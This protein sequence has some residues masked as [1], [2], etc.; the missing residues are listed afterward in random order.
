M[1]FR[2]TRKADKAKEFDEEFSSMNDDFTGV[3]VASNTECTG[4]MSTPP[5]NLQET[6]SYKEIVNV[7]KQGKQNEL[8]R[9]KDKK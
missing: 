6:E 3:D 7:P 4:L 2:I 9:A 5:Q 1:K 8:G